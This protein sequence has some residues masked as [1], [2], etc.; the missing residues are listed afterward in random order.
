MAVLAAPHASTTTSAANC[1]VAP[2]RS[3]TTVVTLVPASFV[4]SLTTSAFVS[5]VTFGCSS[6]GRTPI[7]SASD[8]PCTRHGKPSQFMQRTQALYGM[9]DSS[10]R[11]PQGAWNGW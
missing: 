11:I 5:S 10:S 3:T 2:S 8:L 9:F 1:S 7:T 4:S 6:A